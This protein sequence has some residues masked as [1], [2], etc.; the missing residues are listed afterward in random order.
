MC[1]CA[2]ARACVRHNFPVVASSHMGPVAQA[3][4]RISLPVTV[5]V[6]VWF[7]PKFVIF[8]ITD[9]FYAAN[10]DFRNIL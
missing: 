7:D 4:N 5:L 3:M 6:L 1:V 8:R 2:R 9:C 10:S